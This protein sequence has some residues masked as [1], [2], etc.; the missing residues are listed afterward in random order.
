MRE[1]HANNVYK[2]GAYWCSCYI[3]GWDYLRSELK[4][5]YNGVLVCDKD[6]EYEHPRDQTWDTP[7]ENP[8]TGDTNTDPVDDTL[9][10][11]AMV[12]PARST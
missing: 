4:K 3:C 11:V 7:K 9:S 12:Y 2:P 5:N 1:T 6:F 8:F 10:T